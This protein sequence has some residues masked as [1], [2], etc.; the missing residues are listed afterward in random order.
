M[1]A[2]LKVMNSDRVDSKYLTIK[3][4]L[5]TKT[6]G[7]NRFGPKNTH[8]RFANSFKIKGPSVKAYCRVSS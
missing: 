8:K 1:K 6:P 7:F 2:L 4:K 3:I 5:C